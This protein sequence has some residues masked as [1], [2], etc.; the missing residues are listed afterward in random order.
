MRDSLLL[1]YTTCAAATAGL[2]LGPQSPVP[3]RADVPLRYVALGD[4]YTSAPYVSRVRPGSP[5][6]C[7]RSELNYPGRIALKLHPRDFT[8]V[9]C[10]GAALRHLTSRQGEN[11]PQLDAL[12]ADTTLVTLTMG[13][14]DIG[15]DKWKTCALLSLTDPNGAPCRKRLRRDGGGDP[16]AE[17]F[18]RTGPR[19]GAALR[20]IR[21]RSPLAEVYV[22]GYPMLVPSSGHGCYPRV[23]FARGDVAMV[24]NV[25]RRLN[26][27]LARQARANGAV[28]LDLSAPGH[29]MCQ[30]DDDRRWVEPLLPGMRAA[31]FHPNTNGVAAMT[32]AVLRALRYPVDA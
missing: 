10:S 26:T 30:R 23:P 11:P 21:E 4:S 25:Q 9:S 27:M 13:G 12:K 15:F 14:N 28:F 22:L 29:D 24:R 5:A 17:A 7:R 32:R 18:A 2:L 3:A 20:R 19:F 1:K 16:F 8:D 6:K 31:P